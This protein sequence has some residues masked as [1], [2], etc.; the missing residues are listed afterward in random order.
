MSPE[1]LRTA[2]RLSSRSRGSHAR[3]LEGVADGSTDILVGTQMVAKGHDIPGVT[4]VGIIS[5]DSG[6]QIRDFRAEERTFQLIAQ[7]AGRAGRGEIPGKVFAQTFSPDAPSIVLAARHDFEAFATKEIAFR[8]EWIWPPFTRLLR[9]VVGSPSPEESL[10]ACGACVEASAAVLG[11]EGSL[12]LGPEPAA[13]PF[14]RD[15][16]RY[17]AV[18]RAK[19]WESLWKVASAGTRALRAWKSAEAVWDMDAFDM[20]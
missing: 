11:N 12:T 8:R 19:T 15:R 5:A 4:V 9:L 17:H 2:S 7:V 20:T 16:H 13:I 1:R 14:L 3:I 6:F 10:R 18:F